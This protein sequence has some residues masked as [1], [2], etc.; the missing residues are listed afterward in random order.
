MNAKKAKF[1]RKWSKGYCEAT[2]YP[3][4][5]WRVIYRKFKKEIVRVAR[6]RK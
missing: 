6:E 5:L 2:G 4:S 3:P 1:L